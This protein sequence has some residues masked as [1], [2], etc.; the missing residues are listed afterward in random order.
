[1]KLSTWLEQADWDGIIG[2]NQRRTPQGFEDSAFA[3]RPADDA[4]ADG[5]PQAT[6]LRIVL[7]QALGKETD[8]FAIGVA[9]KHLEA[10]HAALGKATPVILGGTSL[11]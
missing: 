7:G 10:G 5:I 3:T 1:M 8:Q 9:P 11:R 2:A 6:S 4:L